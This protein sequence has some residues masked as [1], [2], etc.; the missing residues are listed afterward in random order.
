MTA[1]LLNNR[2]F[3]NLWS[4]NSV[5]V[6][7][8]LFPSLLSIFAHLNPWKFTHHVCSTCA[9]LCDLVFQKTTIEILLSLFL[10]VY[11]DHQFIL[12]LMVNALLALHESHFK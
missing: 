11:E 2:E 9:S 5:I 8:L 7:F 12:I 6:I 10:D 1:I 4:I 3:P